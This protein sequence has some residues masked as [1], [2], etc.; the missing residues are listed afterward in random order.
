MA[1]PSGNRLAHKR[2]QLQ[3]TVAEHG[4]SPQLLGEI[5]IPFHPWGSRYKVKMSITGSYSTPVIGIVR[6]DLSTAD[7]SECQLPPPHIREFLGVIKETIRTHKLEP[8]DIQART[9]ELKHII[10]ML[11][12]KHTEGIV[13]FILRSPELIPSIQKAV[14]EIPKRFPWATVI[15]CNLQPLP[16]AILEGPEEVILTPQQFM[17][18]DSYDVPLY[19]G[20]Q[21]FMQ[22]TPEIAAQLYRQAS[23]VAAEHSFESALDL[24]CGVGGFSLHVAQHVQHITGVELSPTAI[25][26][27]AQAA[28]DSAITNARFIAADVE[29][30]LGNSP[31]LRPDL[32]IANPPRRGLSDGILKHITRIAPKCVLYSSCNPETFAR[33]VNTLASHFWL[34][35][36]LPFD[37]FP[38]TEHC[39]VLGVL[40]H[41]G[42]Q[43]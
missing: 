35:K 32:V 30:F 29:A 6:K 41:R 16:A 31:D 36:A 2:S 33:D 40:R 25:M 28:K 21:S 3:A 27:A 42:T 20:P 1:I 22:V 39:E 43:T 17:R 12:A 37:M 19:F 18:E 24:F 9:G 23:L 4:I 8:Y 15:S 5:T 10:I 26:C 14:P 34:E 38:L 7:L 13:R 11:N